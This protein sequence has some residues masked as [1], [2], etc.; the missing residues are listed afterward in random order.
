MRETAHEPQLPFQEIGPTSRSWR[1]QF[2]Q[3]TRLSEGIF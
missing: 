3:F 2:M 1:L